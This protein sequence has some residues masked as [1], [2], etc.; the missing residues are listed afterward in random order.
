MNIVGFPQTVL[1]WVGVISAV[2][3]GVAFFFYQLRRNDLK[4]LRDSISDLTKR[5]EFLEKENT[6][7]D[8]AYKDTKY[9]KD[10][11]KQIVVQSLSQK[12][13]IDQSLA[14]EVKEHLKK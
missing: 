1:G 11:L 5:V 14:S 7:L 8:I 6:R 2:A 4:L 3:L 12:A 9:K 10:Y 13:S